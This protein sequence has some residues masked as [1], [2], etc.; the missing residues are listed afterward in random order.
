MIIIM[1]IIIILSSPEQVMRHTTQTRMYQQ[2]VTYKSLKQNTQ[3]GILTK[4][5]FQ[6][7]SDF[8]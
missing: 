7:K 4:S 1:K 6:Y 2:S 5:N 8:I 3:H